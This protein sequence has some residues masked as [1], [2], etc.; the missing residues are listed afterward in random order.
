MLSRV[1]A[2]DLLLKARALG[3]DEAAVV[4]CLELHDWAW[5]HRRQPSPN[6]VAIRRRLHWGWERLAAARGNLVAFI[7]GELAA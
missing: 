3:P 6:W 1:V 7:G 2:A 5:K 4:E